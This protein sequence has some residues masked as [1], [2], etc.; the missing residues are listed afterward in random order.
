M[1]TPFLAR[2]ARIKQTEALPAAAG[3][4]T[5]DAIALP[6]N[7]NSHF[8]AECEVELVAP[9]LTTAELDDDETVVYDLLH[10]HSADLGSPA[11]LLPAVITQTGADAAG[12]AAVTKR[13]RLAS[14]VR[15]YIGLKATSS[16]YAGDLSEKSMTIDVLT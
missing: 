10:S 2:D 3:S 8:L 4:A 12:A 7:P 6:K 1:H 14:D 11:T 16:E 9:A 5:T 15:A 13:V